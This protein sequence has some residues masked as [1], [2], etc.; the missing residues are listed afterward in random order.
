MR[1]L[2][3]LWY[4]LHPLFYPYSRSTSNRSRQPK[5]VYDRIREEPVCVTDGLSDAF[6][7]HGLGIGDR[8]ALREQRVDLA[9][10]D[11]R[12]LEAHQTHH[13]QSVLV[14]GAFVDRFAVDV[15]HPDVMVERGPEQNGRSRQ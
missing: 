8:V 2:S 9:N 7:D 1:S 11:E 14:A 5:R 6:A 13:A 15:G 4:V 10:V 3:Y 12:A